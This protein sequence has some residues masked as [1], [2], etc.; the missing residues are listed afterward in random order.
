MTA[1]AV[2]KQLVDRAIVDATSELV[3]ELLA[4]TP[5]KQQPFTALGLSEHLQQYLEVVDGEL[6][7]KLP[8]CLKEGDVLVCVEST[9]GSDLT[10][11]CRYTI[12]I[13]DYVPCINSDNGFGIEI[14][15][16]HFTKLGL[17]GIKFEIV[18]II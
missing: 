9:P 10:K 5:D 17:C 11:F 1:K 2:L 12:G 16:G 3:K 4:Y 13:Y 15:V 7:P 8:Q 14:E 18:K 6:H